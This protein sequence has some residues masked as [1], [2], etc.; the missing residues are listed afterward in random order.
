[1][2][3][4]DVVI[5]IGESYITRADNGEILET[6]ELGMMPGPD[7]NR[8]PDWAQAAICD[9][10]GIGGDE[11]YRTLLDAVNAA[12]ANAAMVLDRE[13]VRVSL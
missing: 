4:P 7:G 5:R 12:E 3:Q 13:L 11:G 8:A 1:M 9:P 6:V 2:E 10:R